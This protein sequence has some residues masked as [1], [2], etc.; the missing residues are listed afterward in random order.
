MYNIPLCLP[1]LGDEEIASILEVLQK[2]EISHGSKVAEFELNFAAYVGTKHAIAMNSWTSAAF[3]VFSFL[4]EKLGSGEVI[5][6]SLSF[7]ASANVIAN[8]GLTPVFAD[9]DFRTGNV[10]AEDI[11]PLIRKETIAVMPVH[12]AGLP[13][14]MTEIEIL[15]KKNNL[16]LV[17]DSAECVGVYSKGKPAGSFGVGI[18]SFYATKNMTTA[19]GGMVTTNSDELATWLRSRL[20]HGIVKHSYLDADGKSYPWN[21]NAVVP[22][23]NFR[24]SNLQ[25]SLGVVQLKRLAD[26]NSRRHLVAADY[27]QKMRELNQVTLPELMSPDEHSFQMFIIK[28]PKS[29][30]NSL[31]TYLNERGIGA[32]V[33]FDPPIHRQTAYRNS[34]SSLPNTDAFASQCIS[35]PISSKQTTDETKVVVN[36]LKAFLDRSS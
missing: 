14:D 11:E 6:P 32:S 23:H 4:K 36:E 31:V 8:A 25:A 7:V 22:G 16:V 29:I 35:L 12:L 24:L 9:V 13:C 18:F 10:R 27:S 5:L 3:L 1:D 26:M 30:R 28:V 34:V 20:G 33:H 2:G 15:A 17:E 21:R 19:E